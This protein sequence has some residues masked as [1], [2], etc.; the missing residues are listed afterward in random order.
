MTGSFRFTSQAIGA[1]AGSAAAPANFNPDGSHS[2]SVA[3]ANSGTFDTSNLEL[4]ASDI[5]AKTGTPSN[6]F[7]LFSS[8]ADLSISYSATAPEPSALG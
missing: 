2:W 6:R 5:A 3:H 1:N 8:G 7:S 4:D